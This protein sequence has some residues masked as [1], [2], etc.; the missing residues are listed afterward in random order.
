MAGTWDPIDE[1]DYG[2]GI[3]TCTFD[4]IVESIAFLVC[5]QQAR[6]AGFFTDSE[7]DLLRRAAELFNVNLGDCTDDDLSI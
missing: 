7:E 5:I 3:V 6:P 1:G 2:D 4:D